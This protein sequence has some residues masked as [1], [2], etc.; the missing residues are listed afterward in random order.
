MPTNESLNQRL[1]RFHAETVRAVNPPGPDAVR[2]TV[3]LR[4]RRR[5]GA[6]ALAAFLAVASL[7]GVTLLAQPRIGPVEPGPTSPAGPTSTFDSPTPS[8][9]PSP[10]SSATASNRASSSPAKSLSNVPD[11]TVSGPSSLTLQSDGTIYRGQFTLTVTNLGPPY[12]GT[13]VFLTLPAGVD[14]DFS[15]GDP[16]FSACVGHPTLSTP[17]C[18][19]PAIPAGGGVIHP[20]VHV[21]ANYAPQASQLVLPGFSLQYEPT[22]SQANVLPDATPGN[23][24][25]TMTVVLPAT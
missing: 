9:S 10:G 2:R 15:A 22:D 5:S 18:N 23:N 17:A 19:G 21:K 25:V 7:L 1:D 14:I 4:Q 20:V 12:V 11:L 16:G 3:R 8:N 24:T 6:A 13:L